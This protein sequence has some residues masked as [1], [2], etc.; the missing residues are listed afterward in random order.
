M[1]L[2]VAKTLCRSEKISF[3]T[4]DKTNLAMRAWAKYVSERRR[5]RMLSTDCLPERTAY[6]D[7]NRQPATDPN[8][9]IGGSPE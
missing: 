3:R 2:R 4:F 6:P 7:T 8:N 5:L 9:K 1:L